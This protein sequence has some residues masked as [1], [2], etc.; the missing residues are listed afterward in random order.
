MDSRS[1]IEEIGTAYRPAPS[2]A[3]GEMSGRAIEETN[4]VDD[5]ILILSCGCESRRPR[6]QAEMALRHLS[7]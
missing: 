3:P 5:Q 2:S 6:R 1:R 4:D 7:T